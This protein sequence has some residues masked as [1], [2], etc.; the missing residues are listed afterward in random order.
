MESRVPAGHPDAPAYCNAYTHSHPH[1]HPHPHA[2]S[3][4]YAH[5]YTDT[6]SATRRWRRITVAV[7]SVV[8]LERGSNG[9]VLLRVICPS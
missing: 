8:L 5:P 4:A 9:A 6:H 7:R 1:S 2:H 3:H